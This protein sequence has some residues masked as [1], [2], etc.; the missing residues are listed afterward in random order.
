[1]KKLFLLFSVL[2]F[3]F[4]GTVSAFAG[5][6]GYGVRAGYGSNPDQF[7]VGGQALLGEFMKIARFAP[8][9]DYGTGD[10]VSTFAFNADILML[11]KPPNSSFAFYAAA[12][13]TLT[14]WDA[15]HGG[16]DTEIGA[17][18]TAGLR[19][20]MKNTGFYNLEARFGIGDI[21]DLRILFGIMFGGK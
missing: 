9:I 8:S 4:I 5:S 21:P 6:N 15:E 17:T 7:V 12:G 10:N 18:I 20:P 11:L 14:Y 2:C 13:P 19:L 1:M 16:S 3:T